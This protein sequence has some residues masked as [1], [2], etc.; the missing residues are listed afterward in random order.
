MIRHVVVFDWKPEATAEQIAA[1]PEALAGLPAAI[2]EI[3]NYQV[4]S[5]IGVS[6]GNMGFAV[7]ADFDDVD[8]YLVYK[9]HPA[10][11]TVITEKISPIVG[12]RAAVQYE[13]S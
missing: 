12:A 3:R 5:D 6:E 1:V 10:H 2:P 7:V 11:R 13:I 9:D 4:G 8:G